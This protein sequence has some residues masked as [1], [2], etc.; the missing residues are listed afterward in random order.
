MASLD[1]SGTSR[2]SQRRKL[3]FQTRAAQKWLLSYVDKRKDAIIPDFRQ[4]ELRT[5][6]RS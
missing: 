5:R 4:T 3:L 2:I 6:L 1:R